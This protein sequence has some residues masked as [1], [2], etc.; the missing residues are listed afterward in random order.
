MGGD[1]L[2]G[3][4]NHEEIRPQGLKKRLFL[5]L[6]YTATLNIFIMYYLCHNQ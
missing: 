4:I 5:N 3:G 2:A 6:K 1:K